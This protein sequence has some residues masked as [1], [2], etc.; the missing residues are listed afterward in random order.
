MT[1][2]RLRQ[3]EKRIATIKAELTE[4][5]SMRPGSLT[6]QFKDPENQTGGYYQLSYTLDMKSRTEYIRK[7]YVKNVR[8]QIENYK[9]FKQLTHEW[10]T[11]AIEYSKLTM[12]LRLK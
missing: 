1:T 10:I 6:Q 4:I 7:D 2:K 11:L 5:G 8:S 9:R 3:I 12:K